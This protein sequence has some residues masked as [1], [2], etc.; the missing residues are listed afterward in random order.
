MHALPHTRPKRTHRRIPSSAVDAHLARRIPQRDIFLHT[1]IQT[2]L[3]P[4]RE[5]AA[6]CL[7]AFVKA[8]FGYILTIT[9]WD[10]N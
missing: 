8:V 7:D 9:I 5:A 1:L 6:G 10:N 4:G 2:R 3:V